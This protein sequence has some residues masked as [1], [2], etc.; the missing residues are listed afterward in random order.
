MQQAKE[1]YDTPKPVRK[2]TYSTSRAER[3][4]QG[5][6]HVPRPLWLIMSQENMSP[7]F[8]RRPILVC[9]ADPGW[10]TGTSYGIIVFSQWRYQYHRWSWI[11]CHKMVFN[12]GRTSGYNLVYGAYCN[13]GLMRMD[14]K[15]REKFQIENLRLIL[16]VGELCMQKLLFGV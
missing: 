11:W 5:V 12:S 15:P 13:K 2:S 8:R 7:T 14:I 1:D 9:T 3:N 4:A 6:L 16:S 10:V